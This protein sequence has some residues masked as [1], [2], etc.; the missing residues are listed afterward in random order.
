MSAKIIHSNVAKNYALGMPSSGEIYC[1]PLGTSSLTA[2]DVLW[3]NQRSAVAST[4]AVEFGWRGN[5]WEEADQMVKLEVFFSLSVKKNLV[6]LEKRGY[7]SGQ[8]LRDS[9]QFMLFLTN[10]WFMYLNWQLEICR[11]QGPIV[12]MRS[13]RP[14]RVWGQLLEAIVRTNA[15]R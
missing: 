4:S 13:L 9:H 5:E 14:G 15:E 8:M 12:C 7:E 2:S 11:K 3:C 6:G 1:N 10:S